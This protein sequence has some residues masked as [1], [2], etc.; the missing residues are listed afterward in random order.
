MNIESLLKEMPQLNLTIKAGELI[1]FGEN[2]ADRAVK[3][4][5]ERH[6]ER[7]Y[8]RDELVKKFSISEATLW[9]WTKMGLIEG[10]RIGRRIFYAESEVKRL[11]N[12]KGG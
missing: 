2:I 8:T 10:R 11:M 3:V 5:I 4:Y 12:Q 7:V 1:Q 9:R 6:D